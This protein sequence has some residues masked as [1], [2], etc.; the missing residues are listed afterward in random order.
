MWDPFDV[1]VGRADNPSIILTIML[2][3]ERSVQNGYPAPQLATSR[4]TSASVNTE[5]P[6]VHFEHIY[7][8]QA[9]FL[10][11]TFLTLGETTSYY[12]NTRTCPISFKRHR[13]Q[14]C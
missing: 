6:S 12:N 7:V 3:V 5:T 13:F 1:S 8:P 10:F 9:L 11:K 14:G 4:P 2:W